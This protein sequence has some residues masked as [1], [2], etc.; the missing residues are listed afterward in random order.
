VRNYLPAHAICNGYRWDYSP[1][2]SQW[3]MKI[4]IWAR[5]RMEK[6]SGLGQAMLNAFHA[7]E[8]R[9]A[10]RVRRAD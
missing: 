7:Y 6:G 10:K 5:L 1:Q 3:I 2:E 8:I 4:G 9:R